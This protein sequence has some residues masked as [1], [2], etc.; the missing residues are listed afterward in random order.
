MQP[1]RKTVAVLTT[2]LAVLGWTAVAVP[3]ASAAPAPRPVGRSGLPAGVTP[4]AHPTSTSPRAFAAAAPHL[5]NYGGPVVS[6]AEVQSVLWGADSVAHPY[7]PEVTGSVTPN[8]A[9]FFDGVARSPYLSWLSEYN[10]AGQTIGLGSYA[11]S[12]TI[13]P[14]TS[15]TTV[16]ETTIQN[17]LVTDV[18]AGTLPPPTTDAGGNVNT[19]YAVFVPAGIT[20][21]SQGFSS[22]IDFCALHGATT[23]TVGG[24]NLLY[25]V[26]P[27][28]GV[29]AGGCGAGTNFQALTSSAS[30]ELVETITDPQVSLAST[31]GPPL[32]WYDAN[33]G[34]ITDIC[35]DPNTGALQGTVTG[36]DGVQYTVEQSWSNAFGNCILDLD[37]ITAAPSSPSVP[38]G[39][40]VGVTVQGFDEHGT[41]LGNAA[42]SSQLS[43]T[44]PGSC[45]GTSCSATKPGS[46]TITASYGGK[47]ATTSVSVVPGAVDHIVATGPSTVEISTRATFS[48]HAFDA[49]GNSLGDVTSA[50]SLGLGILTFGMCQLNLWCMPLR[51]GPYTLDALYQGKRATTSFTSVDTGSPEGSMIRPT[52]EVVVGS[53]V[54]IAWAGSDLGSGVA[55]FQARYQ[56][57]PWNGG[58][59]PWSYPAAWRAVKA[60]TVTATNLARGYRYCYS[61]RAIDA[62]GNMSPWFAPRCFA[63]PLDDTALAPSAGWTR[64]SS[65]RFFSGTAI[66]TTRRGASLVRTGAR[67]TQVG[68]VATRCASCGVVAVYSGSTYLGRINLA[69]SRTSYRSVLM[70]PR[71][72]LR[73]ATITLRVLSSGK[74]VQVDGL[75]LLPT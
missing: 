33:N 3:A 27:D 60:S 8:M 57:A 18:T 5:T 64:G 58:F 46:Y 59:G 43:M 56:R 29:M 23:A 42:A 53:S 72:S 54:A 15:A 50:S 12:T 61:A 71:V 36:A 34:E 21:T 44:A 20:I 47:T 70:L 39:S 11:G 28:P 16:D 55:A 73:S 49:Y 52:T 24:K 30:H 67:F 22:G 4:V 45:S 17:D 9:T 25:M 74:L 62:V 40:P 51:L 19:V 31:Y 65:T 10:T 35:F 38:A 7:L 13:T 14:S 32:G 37:H 63:V 2:A 69:S 48:I 41:A 75:A 26:L 66:G 6:N 1:V 68:V